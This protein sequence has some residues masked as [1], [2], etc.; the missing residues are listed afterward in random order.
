MKVLPTA[1]AKDGEPECGSAHPLALL[2]HA[3]QPA[4]GQ[5]IPPR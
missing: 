1:R 2:A 4:Q 3:A 5:A